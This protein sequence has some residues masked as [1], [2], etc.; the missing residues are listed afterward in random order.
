MRYTTALALALLATMPAAHARAQAAPPPGGPAPAALPATPQVGEHKR[1][2]VLVWMLDD[3]GFAQLSS[4]G[5]LVDTPNID[6]VAKAG[7]RYSNYHTAPICSATRA[8]FLTG[9]NPH[10]VHIGGH[11]AYARDY[12]GYDAQL[13]PSAGTIA[14]NLRQSGYQTFALGKWDHYPISEGAASGPYVRWPLGQGFDRYYGFLQS[15]IDNWHPQLTRDNSPVAPPARPD[16]HLSTD[17]A[18]EAIAMLGAAAAR[19]DRAPFFLYWA[20][21]VAHAPHHAPAEWIAR[22]RGRFDMGWDKAREMVLKRQ[23]AQGL[24]PATARLAPRPE[25]MPAWAGLSADQKRLYARQMEVFAAALSHADAQFGRIL[26]ELE[27]RG[28]LADTILIVTSDNGASAEGTPSGAYNEHLFTNGTVGNDADNMRFF[29]RW[30][31]P[32]TFP[33]YALGWAVAGNTPFRYY[34]QTAHE[35]GTRVPL[36]VSW[37]KGIAARGEVRRQ[38][39]YVTDIAPTILAAA[40]VTP[41]ER[42]NNVTQSP[43]EGHSFAASFADPRAGD[44][45]RAQYVEIF[46]NKALWMGDWSIVTTHR[47]R[48][49]DFSLAT[50][51]NEP[52]ELYNLAK[53]PGQATD[54]AAR[55][56]DRVRQ[57][58]EAFARQAEAYNV[59]PID[60]A[61]AGTADLAAR[62]KADFVRRKGV[63]TFTG[64]TPRV[65][66]LGSPPVLNASYRFSADVTLPSGHETGPLFAL[67]GSTAGTAFYLDK[68]RPTFIVRGLDGSAMKVAATSALPSGRSTV[69]LEVIRDPSRV[70]AP[71][72]VRATIRA[73]GTVVGEGSG[74]FAIPVAPGEGFAVGQDD[75]QAVSGD[76]PPNTP[77]P[78]TLHKAQFDFSAPSQ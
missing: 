16:Y 34:K 5:G 77:L 18:D 71:V 25:G 11:I 10:S 65:A 76:Y 61:S 27:A 29:D 42:V 51:P 66:P 59:N 32:E 31:G 75:G 53:D 15:E 63:W 64:I 57:M 44:P 20:T 39:A 24:V 37:P 4:F 74:R 19:Q 60:N 58:A 73:N 43:M 72:A 69:D 7:L 30:G 38:F 55:Y 2:N 68:G 49:W 22:Y 23:I 48:T 50:P 78:A 12:P 70:I 40:R 26:D 52:W 21:G 54:L 35:G 41:A 17:L 13:P 3:V 1:P 67:G 14:E 46:G 6:R 62:G 9:R 45:G 56:P 47:T 28:E 36:V 33:H 8:A